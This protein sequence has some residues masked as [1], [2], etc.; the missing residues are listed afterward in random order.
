[1]ETIPLTDSVCCFLIYA[2][3]YFISFFTFGCFKVLS[4]QS[5]RTPYL[6]TVSNEQLDTATYSYSYH[7][8]HENRKVPTII[9]DTFWGDEDVRSIMLCHRFEHHAI[10]QVPLCFKKG[11]KCRFLF[12][13]HYNRF[14]RIDPEDT[15]PD[16]VIPWHQLSDPEV[17]WLSPWMLIPQQDLG[18]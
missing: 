10:S 7:F 13:F 18:C 1:M 5:L 16:V 15:D 14:T 9:A 17:V 12:P 4:P 6:Q 11:C 3:S 2:T 8:L